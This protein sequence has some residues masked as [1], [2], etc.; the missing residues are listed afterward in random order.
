VPPFAFNRDVAAVF[1]DMIGRSVPLYD[2]LIGRQAQIIAACY[3]PGTRIFDLGCSTGNLGVRLCEIMAEVP[4][5]MTAVDN[6]PPMLDIC[7]TKCRKAPGGHRITLMC[8][9]IGRIDLSGAGVVVLNFTLQFLPPADRDRLMARIFTG[10]VSGGT[11][12]LA[13]KVTHR[14]DEFEGLQQAFHQRLKR[15]NGYSA[16]AVAQ[17]REALERV[18][19]P[20]TLETH[21]RRLRA[22]GFR[23]YDIWLKWFNFCAW[24]ARK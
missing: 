13:E 23:R 1:D 16:L 14:D 18:L 4:F 24:I 22:A 19:V 5:E 3:P 11:L 10:L 21:H 17:K 6:A 2:E 15:E 8:A 9:D 20:D 12:L 7:A